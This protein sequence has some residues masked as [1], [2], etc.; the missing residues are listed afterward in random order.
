MPEDSRVLTADMIAALRCPI[1][2]QR[3]APTGTSLKCQRGH[4]FDIARQGYVH[5]GTGGKLPAGDTAEMVEAREAIQSGEGLFAPLEVALPQRC[6]P[7]H[8]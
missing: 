3:L 2:H 6:Q 4:S 7:R 5:L 8:G 1:C